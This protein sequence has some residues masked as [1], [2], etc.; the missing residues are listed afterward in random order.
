ML[1]WTEF[2]SLFAFLQRAPIHAYSVCSTVVQERLHYCPS[3]FSSYG[4]LVMV[5]L[6]GHNV[7]LL[8][9][10]P[11]N[12]QQVFS[13]FKK[14]KKIEVIM[15]KPVLY[16]LFT[17]RNNLFINLTFLLPK[18]CRSRNVSPPL[19]YF[20]KNWL[21]YHLQRVSGDHLLVFSSQPWLWLQ[22]GWCRL[23]LGL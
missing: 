12:A 2:F 5:A 3:S 15:K 6:W 16:A 21:L 4:F 19:L 22:D 20:V 10:S 17:L 11:H 14:R 8:S 18:L 1:Y 23:E 13:F 9:S 7:R